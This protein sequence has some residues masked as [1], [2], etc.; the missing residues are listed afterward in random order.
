MQAD[1][2]TD[3]AELFLFLELSTCVPKAE[4]LAAETVS[5]RRGHSASKIGSKENICTTLDRN[6]YTLEAIRESSGA[7]GR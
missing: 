1:G 5:K 2:L 7:Q 6:R 4:I 3:R